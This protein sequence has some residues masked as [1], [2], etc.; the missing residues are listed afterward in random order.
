MQGD[1]AHPAGLRL[2]GYASIFHARDAGGDVVMPGAFARAVREN[3]GAI[4]LLWQHDAREPIGRVEQLAE[5][6]RGLRVIARISLGCRRGRDAASLI[7]SGA[8]TG[9]SI[10]YRVRRSRIDPARRVRRL[11]DVDLVEISLVT[12]PMQPRARVMGVEGAVA[13]A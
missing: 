4:P 5:D 12:F 13:S 6:G 9:L 7:R 2:A 8:L 11:I 10:G 3:S 1:I